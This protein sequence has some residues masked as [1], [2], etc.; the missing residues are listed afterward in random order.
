MTAIEKICAA[1]QAWWWHLMTL[2]PMA[3]AINAGLTV[4]VVVLAVLLEWG[5]N[6]VMCRALAR[7]P[8]ETEADHNR[9]AAKAL[10]LT[11]W[12]L[13]VVIAAIALVVVAGIWGIDV[14]AWTSQGTGQRIATTTMRVLTVVVLT[15]IA[16]EGA[17]L[18]TRTAIHRLRTHDGNPRREAQLETLGPIVRRILQAIIMVL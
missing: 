10:R 12:A 11:R 4:A 5:V 17:G 6:W 16:M 2:G 18:F 1:G 9:R 3:L 7:L 13:R 14:L 15:A 8:H